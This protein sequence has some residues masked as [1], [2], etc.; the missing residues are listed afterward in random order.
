[1]PG[2]G[3]FGRFF[4]VFGYFFGDC[5]QGAVGFFASFTAGFFPGFGTTAR[6]FGRTARL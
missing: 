6:G 1:M 4:L 2:L 3:D 5:R